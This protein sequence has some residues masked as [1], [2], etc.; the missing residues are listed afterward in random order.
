MG[1]VGS[2][3]V[4]RRR[5]PPVRAIVSPRRPEPRVLA[6]AVA[7]PTRPGLR[8]RGWPGPWCR[9]SR[10]RTPCTV[11]RSGAGAVLLSHHRTSFLA[12]ARY[13]RSSSGGRRTRSRGSSRRRSPSLREAWTAAGRDGRHV[14]EEG[15]TLGR[16]QALPVPQEQQGPQPDLQQDQDRRLEVVA[17]LLPSLQSAAS[18]NGT[19]MIA[20]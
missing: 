3:R 16:G 10:G 12:M 6:S 9:P 11:P 7:A 17:L 15:P 5:S 19:M 2:G 4:P 18:V 1:A 20:V 14:Q 8:T 13:G